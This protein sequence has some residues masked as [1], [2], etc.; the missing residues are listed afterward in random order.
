MQAAQEN[1]SALRHPTQIARVLND[2]MDT[3]TC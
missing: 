3:A 2:E 1:L